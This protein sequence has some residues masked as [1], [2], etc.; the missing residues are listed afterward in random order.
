MTRARPFVKH[1]VIAGFGLAAVAAVAVAE[2]AEANEAN[3]ALRHLSPL[4]AHPW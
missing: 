2:L 3:E 4:R 1:L